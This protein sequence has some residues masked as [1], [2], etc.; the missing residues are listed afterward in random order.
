ME[1]LFTVNEL[2]QDPVALDHY[3]KE[4]EWTIPFPCQVFVT[5]TLV[6]CGVRSGFLV[7]LLQESNY[8]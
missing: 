2:M 4:T 6:S 3:C 8:E 7:R 1:I 5:S